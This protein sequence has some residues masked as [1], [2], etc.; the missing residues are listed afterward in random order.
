MRLRRKAVTGIVIL[1]CFLLQ[2]TVFQTLSIGS[3]AP[4]LLLIV[5]VSFGFMQGKLSGMWS[6][7][8]TA[9]IVLPTPILFALTSANSV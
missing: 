9:K 3:I 8:F 7:G 6:P 1:V 2:S 5:T 4:N